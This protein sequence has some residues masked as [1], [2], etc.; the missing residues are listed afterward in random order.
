MKIKPVKVAKFLSGITLIIALTVTILVAFLVGYIKG[1]AFGK[2][3]QQNLDQK[4]LSQIVSAT[5]RPAASKFASPTPIVI[6]VTPKP[7]AKITWGGPDLWTAVNK[8][9]VELGVNPLSVKDELCTIASI[10]LNEILQLGSLDGHAG[11]STLAGRADIK[12]TFDKYNLSEFLVSG[13]TSAQNAV[14]LWENTL[15]HKEL[16]SG[17]QYVWGCTYAQNGFGVAIAAY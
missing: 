12:P 14:D 10:R 11:F 4:S 3:D 9:R 13:A 7:A 8:R 6:Y 15:G 5:S 16:L 1:Y 17:G 2:T